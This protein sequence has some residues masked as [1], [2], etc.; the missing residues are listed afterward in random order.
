MKKRSVSKIDV[1]IPGKFSTIRA[2][3]SSCAIE[4]NQ[5]AIDALETIRRVEAGEPVGATY[6]IRLNNWLSIIGSSTALKRG[7]VPAVHSET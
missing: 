2:G 6:V 1:L 5:F 7:P 4:G 3:L